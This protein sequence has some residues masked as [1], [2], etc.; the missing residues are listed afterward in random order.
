[1][2]G[3]KSSSDWML[4]C[5]RVFLGASLSLSPPFLYPA[6]LRA[7][8]IFIYRGSQASTSR[9]VSHSGTSDDASFKSKRERIRVGVFADGGGGRGAPWR[10]R[11][12]S[13]AGRRFLR[14]GRQG[15]WRNGP[16]EEPELPLGPGTGQLLGQNARETGPVNLPAVTSGETLGQGGP[17]KRFTLR[18][19]WGL[20]SPSDEAPPNAAGALELPPRRRK[21]RR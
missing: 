7:N 4:V 8:K 17:S 16:G 6:C 21:T 9:Q 2:G 15:A 1:M 18:R 3:K 14:A 19:R 13:V 5:Y 11:S 12:L 10:S 20:S